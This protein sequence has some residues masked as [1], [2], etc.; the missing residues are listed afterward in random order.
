M[1]YGECWVRLVQNIRRRLAKGGAGRG[2]KLRPRS[3]QLFT[4]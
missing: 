3:R 1:Q 4:G 2:R